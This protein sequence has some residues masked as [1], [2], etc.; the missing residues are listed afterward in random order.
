MTGNFS[1]DDFRIHVKLD[2]AHNLTSS[3]LAHQRGALSYQRCAHECI[4]EWILNCY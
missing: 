3:Q 1:V 4:L 2:G